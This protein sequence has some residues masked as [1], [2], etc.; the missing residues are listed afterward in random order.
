MLWNKHDNDSR[1]IRRELFNRLFGDK[2]DAVTAYCDHMSRLLYE[3]GNYHESMRFTPDRAQRLYDG[4]KNM[5]GEL[6]A[7]GPLPGNHQKYFYES[8]EYLR[9]IA[10]ESCGRMD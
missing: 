3:C 1:K 6:K 7:L 2:S 10:A 4:L 9:K 5:D 8:L